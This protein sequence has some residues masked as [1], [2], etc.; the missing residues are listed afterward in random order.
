[1]FKQYFR[2]IQNN[3]IELL[4]LYLKT[5]FAFWWKSVRINVLFCPELAKK[6]D[7]N[8]AG[9]KTRRSSSS[10][11]QPSADMP[12]RQHAHTPTW[13]HPDRSLF[14]LACRRLVRKWQNSQTILW[15]CIYMYISCWCFCATQ[16][17]EERL[18]HSQQ[19]LQVTV[20]FLY[21][22]D[23]CLCNFVEQVY[24]NSAFLKQGK[25]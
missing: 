24:I 14:I 7:T 16:K 21:I 5:L 4:V 9:V 15:H 1:M 19:S 6:K 22:M 23:E 25:V 3:F 2:W 20:N 13:K 18:L 10:R 17:E 8:N 12:T 11:F